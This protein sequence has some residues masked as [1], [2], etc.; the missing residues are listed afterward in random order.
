MSFISL[1]EQDAEDPVGANPTTKET[2]EAP[3]LKVAAVAMATTRP[4]LAQPDVCSM[5]V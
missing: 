5:S 1:W 4:R 2:D 3:L